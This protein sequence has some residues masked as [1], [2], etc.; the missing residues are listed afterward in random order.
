MSAISK[1]ELLQTKVSEP[2]SNNES[3]F[4]KSNL[5]TEESQIIED[6]NVQTEEQILESSSDEEKEQL[7]VQV[8]KSQK[9]FSIWT[10]SQ[11]IRDK[12]VSLKFSIHL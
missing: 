12:L 11:K 1:P 9:E 8:R 7:E 10:H 4:I 6:K 2:Q 5:E 3:I